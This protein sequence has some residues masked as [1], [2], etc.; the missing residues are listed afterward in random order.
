[1]ARRKRVETV[2]A[3]RADAASDARYEQLMKEIE[4]KFGPGTVIRLGELTAEYPHLETGILSLDEATGIGGL[5]AG[6]I[7]EIFGPEAA[8][9][10]MLSL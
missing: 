9:M 7:V 10:T 5:P 6:R 1:M 2:G 8:G 4:Q 3:A